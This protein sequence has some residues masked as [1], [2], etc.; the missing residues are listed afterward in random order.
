VIVVTSSNWAYVL[1]LVTLVT[2]LVLTL[3]F[4]IWSHIKK[5]DI[6]YLFPVWRTETKRMPRQLTTR[7]RYL[8]Y[9]CKAS[10][11]VMFISLALV[12]FIDWIKVF[13]V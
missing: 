13:R 6:G 4:D 8:W 1:A 9:V 7:Q 10:W 2:H 12:L 3:A 5:Q 11:W